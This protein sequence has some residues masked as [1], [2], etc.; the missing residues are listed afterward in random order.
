MNAF[1]ITALLVLFSNVL[2]GLL[3]LFKGKSKSIENN[4][5]WTCL[6]SATWALG[7][8]F[9]ALSK[10]EDAALFW[11]KIAH[12]GII[13]TPTF[14][15]LFVFSFTNNVNKLLNNAIYFLAASF[16]F[17]T[18]FF[19]SFF[20]IKFIF[21]QFYFFQATPFKNP[22]Y[23]TFYFIFYWVILLYAFF[24]L[25]KL[26]NVSV[27]IKRNQIKYFIIGMIIAW[28][29]PEGMFLAVFGIPL[30][31]YSN[32]FIS[33]YP[34]IFSYAILRY[35]LL[36]VRV[37][38]TRASI[39][40]F[41]YFLVLGLPF[42]IGFRSLG[43][44]LWILP[45][46]IMAIL[47]TLG[48]FIYQY[49][50]R[51]AEEAL[52]IEQRRYQEAL[53]KLSKTMT[54]IR[55]LDE[56]LK[57]ISK[58]VVDTVRLS[59]SAIYL[60]EE[61][62]HSFQLKSFYSKDT[63]PKPEDSILLEHPLTKLLSSQRKPL[64]AEELAT[65]NK[66]SFD[67]GLVTPCFIEDDLIGIMLFGT[68]PNNVMYT[69]DDVLSF[70]TLSYSTSLG[71]ENCL[72]WKEIEDRHRK[73]RLQEMDTYSYS[74]AHEI[75]NPMQVVLGQAGLLK[76]EMSDSVTDEA[77][78]KDINNSFDFIIEAAKR[79][80]GMVKA[81]RDF[82]QKTTGEFHPLSIEDVAESF[83]KLYYPQFKD[84]AVLFEKIN[85]LKHPVFVRGE[86]PELM[87]VLV[88]LANNSVHALT[89]LKEKKAALTLSLSSQ[90]FIRMT[91]SDNGYGIKKEMVEIIFAP[92]TTTKASTEGTGMG[93]YNAK[94]I[95]NKH[96]GRIWAESEG[97]GKGASFVI[98]LPIAKDVTAEELNNEDKKTKR[99]I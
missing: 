34:I 77:K 33:I 36:D 2:I 72:F 67:F 45:V 61:T 24:L 85:N 89:G 1:A 29:G 71:I 87:Q 16:L 46:S 53:M 90:D 39:F 4:I 56:L 81:I 91:F 20:S 37:A 25:I 52:L 83:A 13:L 95:I 22:A 98:E 30:Y 8:F 70:E 18:F 5:G 47:A 74:L 97:P 3:F 6:A 11:S 59:Y 80:S 66:L 55:N 23:T 65:Q 38:I 12:I 31:P 64:L 42:W 82:G 48:P 17:L 49:L 7:A 44:G 54:R 86:K 99:L 96:K 57:I 9:L 92:F 75:D 35:R 88:I 27:G 73:A 19:R 63:Q 78:R 68:K 10:T 43:K 15:C 32:I 28:L 84:K 79:V 21:N 51:R 94:N 40:S 76:K 62:Y 69:T 50:R 14:F 93:L 41:V 26:F 60:K 58:T